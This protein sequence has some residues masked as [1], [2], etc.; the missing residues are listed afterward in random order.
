LPALK[1]AGMAFEIVD[2]GTWLEKVGESEEDVK[3]NPSRKLVDF[4]EE[5]GRVT[6]EMRGKM[7]FSRVEAERRSEALGNAESLVENGMIKPLVEAWI[8][9]W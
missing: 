1:D 9:V 4:W 6:E 5:Q 7:L 2:Y 8:E 3:R